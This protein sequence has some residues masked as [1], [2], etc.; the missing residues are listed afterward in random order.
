[1]QA[2]KQKRKLKKI[3]QSNVL[4][5]TTKN[6]E[7]HHCTL[8]QIGKHAKCSPLEGTKQEKKKENEE[9]GKY[10]HKS[11]SALCVSSLADA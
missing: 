7:T 1:M 9:K 8:C 11:S 6:T 5:N 4:V 10:V 3:L 2:L